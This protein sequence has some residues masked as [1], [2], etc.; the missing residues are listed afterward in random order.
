MEEKTKSKSV[1]YNLDKSYRIQKTKDKL[2][3]TEKKEN[4]K[5]RH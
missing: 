5:G 3:L 1:Y 2:K 4:N